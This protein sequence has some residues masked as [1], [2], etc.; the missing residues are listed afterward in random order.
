MKKYLAPCLIFLVGGIYYYLQACPTFYFWDSAELTTAVLSNGVPHPPGFPFFLL[1]SQLWSR[2]IPLDKPYALNLF[3]EFF[4]ALGLTLWYLVVSKILSLVG[5]VKDKIAIEFVSILAVIVLGVSFTYSIQATR[6]EVYSLNFFGFAAI[7]LIALTI[8]DNQYNSIKL[9]ILLFIMYGLFLGVHN[10][11]IAL[12]IPGVLTLLLLDK[13]IKIHHAFFGLFGS[14]A[15]AILFYIIIFARA[16]S[17]PTLN[18]GNPSSF[19]R[20]IDYILVRGFSTSPTRLTASHF[21]DL[22]AFVSNIV[23]KQ[24]GIVGLLVSL[25]GIFVVWIKKPRIG[26]PLIMIMILNS[27]SVGLAE[28]YFYENYDLHGYLVISVALLVIFMAASILFIYEYL[29]KKL[30]VPKIKSSPVLSFLIVTVI[31]ALTLGPAISAN[32]YS[33]D[34][35]KVRTAEIYAA[36]FLEGAPENAIIITSSYNTYFCAMAAHSASPRNLKQPIENLYDWDHQWGREEANRNLGC[37]IKTDIGRQEFYRGI[38]N[39]FIKERPIYVEYDESS[40]PLA[41]Y[42]YPHGLGYLLSISDTLSTAPAVEVKNIDSQLNSF[43]P[44]HD[45]ETIR[46]VV[47]WLQCRGKYYEQRG[48]SLSAAQYYNA[49]D[50]LASMAEMQ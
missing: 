8:L 15:I 25:A 30:A 31:A 42:L 37:N 20:L 7:L 24:L 48:D 32:I 5:Y 47:L 46:T 3:S 9:T 34:L 13:K 10:L 50:S 40:A 27:I 29:I 6:F 39:K 38:L 45:I 44:S 11:T 12:T 18:W 21:G 35:S 43:G 33:A 49:V 22:I 26:L 23:S 2:I 36:K 28:N 16:A 17:H 19:N 1:L 41:K 4:A 14:I